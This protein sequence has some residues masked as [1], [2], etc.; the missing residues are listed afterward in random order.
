MKK[1]IVKFSIEI[2]APTKKVWEALTNPDV[3]K[4]YFFGT[5]VDTTWK[6]GSPIFWRGSW[7][8][9]AYEDKGTILDLNPEKQLA[10]TYW[11]SFSGVADVPE[12]YKTLIY[13]LEKKGDRTILTLTQDN[14]ADEEAAKHSEGNWKTIFEGMK[15]L[16][17][18]PAGV[19]R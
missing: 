1:H 18:A 16:L 12:N 17:E 6:V 11:G 5:H 8:G 3:I 9:K 14:N 2:K 4:K 7:Q 10:C 13:D 19:L 15:K